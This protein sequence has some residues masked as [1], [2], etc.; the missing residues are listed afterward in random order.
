MDDNVNN[1]FNLFHDI[2]LSSIDQFALEK[3]IKLTNRQL[4]REPWIIGLLKSFI[5]QCKY[6]KQA[7]RNKDNSK[8]WEKYKSYKVTLDIEIFKNEL[9]SK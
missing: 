7:L 2:F 5:K 8:L 4:K 9:F 1:D 3:K 6:Y